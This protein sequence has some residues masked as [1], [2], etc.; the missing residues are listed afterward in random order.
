MERCF[1]PSACDYWA[2]SIAVAAGDL[3][4]SQKLQ[5]HV[6]F[7]QVFFESYDTA[8]R[9][10]PQGVNGR[11]IYNELRVLLNSQCPITWPWRNGPEHPYVIDDSMP[12]A[13]LP[14]CDVLTVDLFEHVLQ[15]KNFFPMYEK[16]LSLLEELAD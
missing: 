11:V 6:I 2:L 14:L 3:P 10:F 5:V 13:A 15:R 7:L 12:A 9:N 4:T 1:Q 8:W 16:D